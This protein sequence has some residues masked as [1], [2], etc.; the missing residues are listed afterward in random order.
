MADERDPY[1]RQQPGN[2]T[3]Y[4]SLSWTQMTYRSQSFKR[5]TPN[6]WH[7]ADSAILASN[8]IILEY[9]RKILS[10]HNRIEWQIAYVSRRKKS[11]FK[12]LWVSELIG[13]E[14]HTI[15][16]SMITVWAKCGMPEL[17]KKPT[18][19]SDTTTFTPKTTKHVDPQA[20]TLRIPKQKKR[21]I[22]CVK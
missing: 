13:F 19:Q 16:V 2:E 8:Y 10:L 17:I 14:Y 12:E 3:W 15:F 9:S 18:K 1:A 21:K 7:E 22:T 4:H 20:V 6:T 11:I 5:T